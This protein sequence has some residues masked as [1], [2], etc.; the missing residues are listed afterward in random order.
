M[1]PKIHFEKESSCARNLLLA[2]GGQQELDRKV[3]FQEREDRTS[4]ACHSGC[5]RGVLCAMIATRIAASQ[6]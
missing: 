6:L 2:R 4:L 3:K 1:P 5:C